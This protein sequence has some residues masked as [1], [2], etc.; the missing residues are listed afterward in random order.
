MIHIP[1]IRVLVVD[2]EPYLCDLSKEF[3]ERSEDI[4]VEIAYSVSKAR[5]ILGQ[6]HFDGI[7]SDYQMPGEDGIQFLK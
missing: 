2:D 4:E 1:S 7:V 3:L 5:T 6:S